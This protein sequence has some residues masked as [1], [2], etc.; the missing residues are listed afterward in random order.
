MRSDSIKLGND[1]S[2][3]AS[4]N[5]FA[6]KLKEVQ[7]PSIVS[8]NYVDSLPMTHCP[9][10]DFKQSLYRYYTITHDQ[11][12]VIKANTQQLLSANSTNKKMKKDLL[13]SHF[14]LGFHDVPTPSE[15]QS[16]FYKKKSE[17]DKMSQLREKFK[18]K[19]EKQNFMI[20]KMNP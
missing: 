19:I 10:G 14:G 13:T 17:A 9:S 1:N 18:K 7:V 12:R 16:N 8:R 6:K 4:F 20:S 3:I 15:S 11:K 2:P 5:P